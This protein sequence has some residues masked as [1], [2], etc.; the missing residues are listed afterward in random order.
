MQ[1][2]YNFT[3]KLILVFSILIAACGKKPETST[4][5][6][7]STIGQKT[8]VKT[9]NPISSAGLASI[10][11]LAIISSDKEVKPAFKTGGVIAKTFFKEGDAVKKGQLLATLVMGEINAELRKAEEALGKA[12]RDVNRI[13]N[14]YVD[15]VATLEQY[16]NTKTAFEMASKTL[17]IAKFNRQY[18]EV[19][20]PIA[21]R[22][23]KQIMHEGEIVSPGTPVYAI[24]GNGSSDWKINA[25]LVDRDWAIVK[26]GDSGQLILD[27]YPGKVYGV[28]VSEKSIISGNASSTID[29]ELK[30]KHP[31]QNL[32]AGLIG[33]VSIQPQRNGVTTM[34]LPIE[35]L[36]K[37]N[38]NEAVVYVVENNKAKKTIIKIGSIL[39]DNVELTSG[40]DV[41]Q[42]VIT[43][44]S[45][46][47]ED[48]DMVEV[49][50]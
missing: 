44:G 31:T 40:L 15:S 21:G 49:R 43:I 17:E 4:L 20:S 32:A 37:S 50:N 30:F 36:T 26:V 25:G 5:V 22:I 19:R 13:S 38:G 6:K 1:I 29:V 10:N 11:V 14:L 48:G 3:H 41:K 8:I 12:S 35:A 7:E 33:K 27:A 42:E 24:M 46:Y 23:I 16:Q 47:I 2:K 9:A 28:T 39:G 18:S 45:M 34:F